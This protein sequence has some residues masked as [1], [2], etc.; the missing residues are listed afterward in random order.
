MVKGEFFSKGV[1]G[2]DIYTFEL[3]CDECKRKFEEEEI[4]SPASR[5][6]KYKSTKKTLCPFCHENM[7]EGDFYAEH[8][9]TGEDIYIYDPC[10]EECWKELSKDFGEEAFG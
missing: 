5:S 6:R 3:C 10:C 4:Q 1:D 9:D 8:P 7:V 2:E